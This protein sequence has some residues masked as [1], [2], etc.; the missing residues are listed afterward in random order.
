MFVHF[1]TDRCSSSRRSL[2]AERV[3]FEI[4]DGAESPQ[5]ANVLA[6]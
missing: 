3:E 4:G 5:P 1:W 2:S 6:V